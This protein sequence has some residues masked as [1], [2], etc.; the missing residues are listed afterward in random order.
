[1]K[2]YIEKIKQSL[3]DK[4][5]SSDI[6][7]LAFRDLPEGGKECYNASMII[8]NVNLMNGRYKTLEEADELVDEFLSISLP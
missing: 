6:E 8:G 2:N 5:N 4:T 7:S 1:M 3:R